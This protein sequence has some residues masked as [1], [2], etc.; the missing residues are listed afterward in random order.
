MTVASHLHIRLEEYDERILTFIPG[1]AAMLDAAVEAVSAVAGDSPQIVDLGTGT[2]ALARRCLIA[3]PSARLTAIDA[4]PEIL[5]LA[6]QR[7]HDLPNQ[8]A[9]LHG[10]FTTMA[11]PP[12]DALV[13]SLALH[14]IRTADEKRAFYARCHTALRPGGILVSADC[15]PA[16]DPQL[17][18]QQFEAWRAH[19]RRSY[20][21]AETDG[22]FAA[23]ADEDVYFPLAEEL[24]MLQG[25]GFT[26]DIVWREG[27]MGVIAAKR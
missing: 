12:C 27:A 16:S 21:D 13:A 22:F 26:T 14:H 20:S 10:N 11:L 25:A 18:A 4:D 3:R 24:T 19:L 6:A 8:P 7:L 1:Y 9:F 17:R 5:A 23:W 2:G 15:C